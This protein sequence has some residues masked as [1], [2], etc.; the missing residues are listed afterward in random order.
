LTGGVKC[1]TAGVTP[2]RD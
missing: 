2:G 1:L